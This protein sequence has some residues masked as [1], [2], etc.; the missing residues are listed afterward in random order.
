MPLLHSSELTSKSLLSCNFINHTDTTHSQNH[1][2]VKKT[3]LSWLLQ[4]LSQCSVQKTMYNWKNF[5]T[6]EKQHCR[7][8]CLQPIVSVHHGLGKSHKSKAIRSHTTDRCCSKGTFHDLVNCTPCN[9]GIVNM[10]VQGQYSQSLTSGDTITFVR[11]HMTN[12]RHISVYGETAHSWHCA[13]RAWLC[14]RNAVACG[15]QRVRCQPREIPWKR[16]YPRK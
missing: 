13:K 15:R 11:L 1:C 12:T 14:T 8:T 16:L 10:A 5:N 7:A 3:S 6:A 2:W 9:G 4:Q